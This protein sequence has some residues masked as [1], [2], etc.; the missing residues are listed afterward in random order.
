VAADTYFLHYAPQGNFEG[1]V[2][3]PYGSQA[4]AERQAAADLGNDMPADMLVGIFTA[5][6]E[7]PRWGWSQ[8]VLDG[9]AAQHD[10][11]PHLHPANRT[12]VATP[13]QILQRAAAHQEAMYQEELAATTDAILDIHQVVRTG[14]GPGAPQA[15]V[16]GNAYLVLTGCTATGGAV[17]LVA[18]TAKTLV[19]VAAAT[20]NPPSL[21]EVQI[22]FDGVTASAV[23]VLVELVSGTGATA[24]TNTAQTPKQLRGWPAAP[25]QTTGAH[26]YT[27]EPTVQLVNRKWDIT[28]NGGMLVLQFPLGREPT[29][30]V[31]AATDA[32]TW[33]LRAT[34]PAAVNAHAYIEFEE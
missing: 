11:A 31:T 22:S 33:S 9:T 19:L 1:G 34:A 8:R 15:A 30:L 4:E 10:L 32:K 3:L 13:K 2:Y 20:A 29:G 14:R 24:G 6:Y 28:P 17:G 16:P 21:V 7:P 27:A 5:P 25:S 12:A 18:A 26:T 23:P